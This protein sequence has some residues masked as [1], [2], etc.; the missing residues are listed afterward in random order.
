MFYT[1][2]QNNSG[3]SFKVNSDVTQYVIIEADN[4]NDANEKAEFIGLYW[5]GVDEGNDCECCGDR[6]FP[7][8]A[9]AGTK[10]PEIYCEDPALHANAFAKTGE[11]YCHVYFLNGSKQT[12]S[13]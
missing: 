4:H 7:S 2:S 8:Y 1:Y 3:G 11:P 10:K 12:Y 13:K 6:W 5:N 9:A